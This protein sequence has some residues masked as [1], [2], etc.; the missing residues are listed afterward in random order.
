[1]LISIQEAIDIGTHLISKEGIGK[2]VTYKETFE[3]LGQAKIIPEEIAEELSDLVGFRNVLV[4][5]YW[6]LDIDQV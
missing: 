2:P 6:Q 5:I 4:H 1:M 3:L